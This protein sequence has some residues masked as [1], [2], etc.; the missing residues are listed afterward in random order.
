MNISAV[1]RLQM[2]RKKISTPKLSELSGVSKGSIT[3]MRSA[4]NKNI[5]IDT[6]LR[7]APHLDTTVHELIQQAEQAEQE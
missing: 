2:A 3:R 4:H 5:T 6:L 7:I 1:I